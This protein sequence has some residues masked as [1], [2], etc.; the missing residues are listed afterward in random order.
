MTNRRSRGLSCLDIRPHRVGERK[1]R[2]GPFWPLMY[3]PERS[4]PFRIVVL[5]AMFLIVGAWHAGAAC[6]WTQRAGVPYIDCH[7]GPAT[8]S[9]RATP[10]W[11]PSPA[12]D[13]PPP[14][15][16]DAPLQPPI[17]G[18]PAPPLAPAAPLGPSITTEPAPMPRYRPPPPPPTLNP[19][20]PGL[21]SPPG[22]APALPGAR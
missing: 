19:S 13:V 17:A 15:L 7:P 14:P 11:Q 9:P 12:P 4:N 16:A 2:S 21:L 8:L 3:V 1:G 18:T 5:A 20:S 10:S 22:H 6:E